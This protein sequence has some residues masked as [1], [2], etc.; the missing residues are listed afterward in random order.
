MADGTTTDEQP[1]PTRVYTRQE[2]AAL[3]AD[4]IDARWA[5]L[6]AALSE[7]RVV[8]DEAEKARREAAR[9]EQQR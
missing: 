9:Q 4:E 5:E 2:V 7:G 1:D 6:S 3:S 8:H